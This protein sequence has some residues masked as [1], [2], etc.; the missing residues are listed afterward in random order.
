MPLAILL[1]ACG[2]EA[3]KVDPA[4]CEKPPPTSKACQ[5]M[6]CISGDA[7]WRFQQLPPGASCA[8][9]A[10]R[11]DAGGRCVKAPL[12]VRQ[13]WAGNVTP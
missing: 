9:D 7:A 11:C 8:N 4:L 13:H 2:R 6:M 5:V 1:A 12:A 10:G 3:P